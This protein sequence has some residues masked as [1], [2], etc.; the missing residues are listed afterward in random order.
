M[1]M[2]S[3]SLTT[4]PNSSETMGG[5]IGSLNPITKAEAEAAC[6]A[7]FEAF[8]SIKGD[9]AE[10][11]AAAFVDRFYDFDG[12][13]IFKPTTA[14]VVMDKAGAVA[15]FVGQKGLIGLADPPIK[16]EIK[17]FVNDTSSGNAFVFGD[18]TIKLKMVPD[19]VKD[20]L[21]KLKIELLED[22]L[23][24]KF[25]FTMGFKRTGSRGPGDIKA[26]VH[27]NV[28]RASPK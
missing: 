10:A 9:K 8:L 6:A 21:Q 26:F 16:F 11:E 22:G 25:D 23:S 27:H 18:W 3:N 17:A 2:S 28:W 14:D 12:G 5:C 1:I 15:Y 4:S 19:P 20:I 13:A 24:A 7:W